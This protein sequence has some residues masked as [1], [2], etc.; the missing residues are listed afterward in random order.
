[1]AEKHAASRIH[2]SLRLLRENHLL[3][4]WTISTMHKSDGRSMPRPELVT[5]SLSHRPQVRRRWLLPRAHRLPMGFTQRAGSNLGTDEWILHTSIT[6]TSYSVTRPHQQCSASFCPRATFY[7]FPIALM[8][9]GS[10]SDWWDGW[11]WREEWQDS[12]SPNPMPT[13]QAPDEQV[14]NAVHRLQD[15]LQQMTAM[16]KRRSHK[17][18]TERATSISKGNDAY[19]AMEAVIMAREWQ[20]EAKRAYDQKFAEAA[21]AEETYHDAIRRTLEKTEALEKHVKT[22]TMRADSSAFNETDFFQTLIERQEET[23]RNLNTL[24]S[25]LCKSSSTQ[26]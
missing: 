15:R 20:A 12:S 8:S 14:I 25:Q 10:S 26:W 9:G 24:Y 4:Q 7:C 21:V 22:V 5:T 2:Q 6:R 11:E 1:M 19:A 17:T 23:I 16:T 18:G 13:E 3:S